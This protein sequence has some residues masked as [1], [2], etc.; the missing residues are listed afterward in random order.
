MQPRKIKKAA[1][2][3]PQV[4][5]IGVAGQ[6]ATIGIRGSRYSIKRQPD[7]ITIGKL[8]TRPKVVRK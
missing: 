7:I 6:R 2:K 3:K 1:K 5:L 8:P 4:P